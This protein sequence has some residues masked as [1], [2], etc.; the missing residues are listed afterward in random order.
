MQGKN[1]KWMYFLVVGTNFGF[2]V[3]AGLLAGRYIDS[4]FG[5]ETPYFTVLGLLAGVTSGIM[6]LI[7]ILNMKDGKK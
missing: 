2:S 3:A 5:F 1:K 6:L 4:R 7:K